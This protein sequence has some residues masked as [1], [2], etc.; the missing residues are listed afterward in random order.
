MTVK[1]GT[2]NVT[3]FD[4]LT[5]EVALAVEPGTALFSAST[6]L[7]LT[8]ANPIYEISG[9]ES[10]AFDTLT[11]EEVL[12][13]QIGDLIVEVFDALEIAEDLTYLLEVLAPINL[14]VSEELAL[15]EVSLY[16][17]G[18]L[19]SQA[20]EELTIS[21]VSS[22]EWLNL[23]VELDDNLT[24]TDVPDYGLNPILIQLVDLVRL[25]EELHLTIPDVITGL[26]RHIPTIPIIPKMPTFGKRKM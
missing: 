22:Y 9:L 10:I 4:T 2:I 24:I 23:I 25:A 19:F 20:V 6:E 18:I 1:V 26:I 16:E 12:S 11:F 15:A 21:E 5:T 13:N 3:Q 14:S 8:D 7:V 17:W